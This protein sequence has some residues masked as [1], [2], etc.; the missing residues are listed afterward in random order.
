MKTPTGGRLIAFVTNNAGRVEGWHKKDDIYGP[1]LLIINETAEVDDPILQAF[2][3]CTPNAVMYLSKPGLMMGRFYDTHTK[4]R[5][6]WKCIQAGLKDCPHIPK[7]RIDFIL[8]HYGEEHPF[9]RSTLYGEFME[10]DEANRY[11]VS[12]SS[13]ER[14]ISNPAPYRPGVRVAFCDFAAGGDENV[15]ALRDGNR[16]TLEAHWRE[17]DKRAAVYRFIQEFR[18]LK[19]KGEDIWGDAAAKDIIDMLYAS[20]WEINR[21]NFGDRNCQDI[22]MSWGAQAWLELAISIEKCEVTLPVDDTLKAQLTSRMKKPSATGKQGIEEKWFMAKRN[23]PSPDRGD[24]VAGCWG[25]FPPEMATKTGIDLSEFQDRFDFAEH[26]EQ[27]EEI[28]AWAGG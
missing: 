9:T 17:K 25:V 22:Y 27:M 11:I 23:I 19:L 2:D 8:E 20:G 4:Y 24:A 5:A 21:K 10:Q 26:K 13:L 12:L 28:G 14:C 18:R 1:L 16:I 7:E 6:S 3:R 15:I